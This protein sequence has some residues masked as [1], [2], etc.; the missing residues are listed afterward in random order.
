MNKLRSATDSIKE[1]LFWF[2]GALI[3]ANVG[4]VLTEH[5]GMWD[6]FWWSWVTGTTTGYG[7]TYP[8]TTAGR[9]ITVLWMAFMFIWACV[10][11]ARLASHMIVDNDA[12]T[13]DEQEEL[14]AGLREIRNLLTNKESP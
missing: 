2:W 13:N 10:F 14:K 12:F 5:V 8:H 6:A 4:Y 11:T 7:D 9:I 3:L 1:L